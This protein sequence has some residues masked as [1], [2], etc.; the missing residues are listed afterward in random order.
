MIEV[1]VN[2]LTEESANPWLEVRRAIVGGDGR[3]YGARGGVIPH[4]F[5]DVGDMHEAA[6]VIGNWC[7]GVLGPALN[8]A[9]MRVSIGFTG[10]EAFFALD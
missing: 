2:R 8:M 4:D 6:Q 5:S 10:S 9:T 3:T 1:G 7:A